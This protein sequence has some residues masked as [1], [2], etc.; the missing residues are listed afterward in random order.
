ML[1]AKPVSLPSDAVAQLTSVIQDA[2]PEQCPALMGQLE[3]WKAAL[4]LRMTRGTPGVSAPEDRLLTAEE[5]AQ[6][7]NVSIDYVYR[8][9][10]EF[11]FML[12]EGRAVRF[13]QLGLER[14][15]KQRQTR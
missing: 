8:H 5:V 4:W 3:A 15:L 2:T 6:R 11:P 13:S 10:R 9:A 7:L 14:Y 12:R 1:T